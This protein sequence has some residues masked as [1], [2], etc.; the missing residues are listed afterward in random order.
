MN[1][2]LI[3]L[4]IGNTRTKFARFGKLGEIAELEIWNSAN[5][6]R[7]LCSWVQKQPTEWKFMLGWISTSHS[8]DLSGL[9]CWNLFENRPSFYPI[10]TGIE[11][12]IK[13]NYQTPET[14]GIDRITGVIAACN[15]SEG[16]PVLIIDMGT[17]ITYDFADREGIYRGGGI[18]PG[19]EMRFKALNSFTARLPLVKASKFPSLLGDSTTTCILSGVIHGIQAEV[20]EIIRRYKTEFGDNV[21]IFLTGGDAPFFENH[22]KNINFADSNLILKGIYYI[23]THKSPL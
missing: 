1:T 9:T 21:Q 3:G 14:L 20:T 5:L 10:H 23:L 6:E 11:L 17:A 4:D 8:M 16:N 15:V 12:P 22:L 18:S 13:N 2:H 7:K 19:M